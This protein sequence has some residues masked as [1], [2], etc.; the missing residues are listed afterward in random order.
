MKHFNYLFIALLL[1]LVGIPV[2]AEIINEED[3]FFCGFDTEEE[4]NQW[5]VIDING[6]ADNG[7]SVFWWEERNGSAYISTA[8]NHGTDDWIFSPAVTLSGTKSY[9]IKIKFYGYKDKIK[10]TMGTEATVEAQ[11]TILAEEAVYDGTRYLKF[12]LPK[13][14]KAGKYYFGA[15]T[16]SKPWEG[17]FQI[18]SFEVTEAQS[19]KLEV[20]IKNKET[21]KVINNA[22]ATL[23]GTSGTFYEDL[24]LRKATEGKYIY[25]NLN[26]GTYQISTLLDGFFPIEK[27]EVVIKEGTN[28]LTLEISPIPV[29]TVSGKVTDEAGAPIAGAKVTMKGILIYDTTTNETGEFKIEN[30]RQSELPYLV[31]IKKD[32]KASYNQEFTI[33]SETTDLKTII[34]KDY[35][36][37]PTNICAD[38]TEKGMFLSWMMPL[39]EK[40]FAHDNEQFGGRYQQNAPYA[41]VGVCFNEPMILHSMSWVVADIEDQLI[42]LYVF[43]INKDG[44][45]SNTPIYEKKQVATRNYDYEDVMGWNTYLFPEPI[46]APYGCIVALGHAQSITVCSDYQR[47]TWNSLMSAGDGWRNNNEVSNFFIR[48]NG[49]GLSSDLGQTNPAQAVR[50]SSFN[51]IRKVQAKQIDNQRFSF[52]IWRFEAKD[53]ENQAAWTEISKDVKD[54]YLIDKSFNKLPIG[55]YYYAVQTIYTDGK[56]SKISY[57]NLIEHEIYT[58]VTA[59]IFTNTAINFAKGTTVKLTNLSDDRLTYTAT[60]KNE[61]LV[62]DKIRKGKYIATATKDGFKVAQTGELSFDKEISYNFNLEMQLSPIAPINLQAEQ[63]EG[64]TDITLSWNKMN[65]IFDDFEGMEDFSLNPA[66]ELGWTY[67]DVDGGKTYGIKQCESTPYPNMFEPM[68]FM[69]F[70]PTATTPNVIE[71]IQPYSGNKM[72]VSVAL[73][74]GGANDD[75]MFS[76][77]LKFERDFTLSFYACAGFYAAFGNEKFMVGYTTEEAKPENVTWLTE[78]A[79]SVGAMW[80]QFTYH[81]PKEARHTVIRCVSSQCMFFMVDDV[82]IGQE[83]PDVFAMATYNVT[84]DEEPAGTTTEKSIVLEGL[85]EGKH[86]AKVQT[87]YTMNDLSK[88]YSDFTEL[89]FTVKEAVGMDSKEANVLYTYNAETGVI[90]LSDTAEKAEL[91]NVQGNLCATCMTGETIDTQALQTGVYV[92]KIQAEGETSFGKILVK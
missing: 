49:E 37:T 72:L 38:L 23:Y 45:Y 84:V 46:A 36:G 77:E 1:S 85:S 39:G 62:F 9:A 65:T 26:L 70:N 20:T 25:D 89:I 55:E 56:K 43:P 76:P 53:K 66:G 6:P 13:D 17:E 63:A 42:D 12:D 87:V 54:L 59:N 14:T 22:E 86:I 15:H 10:F 82:L 41:Y 5:K 35:I 71:F 48:A 61:V 64:A 2:H 24:W 32:L 51:P 69:A 67:A 68:A 16:V 91:Y 28:S 50:L 92:L 31:S 30:V 75:Y 27:Q 60:A 90:A 83:E 19:S 80:T 52:S 79:E 81:M 57:S 58:K 47:N 34:L 3:H 73:E 88:Q 21:Q 18:Y 40:A 11:T 7:N 74:T 8:W 44:S 78:E 33:N 29:S 4:Y